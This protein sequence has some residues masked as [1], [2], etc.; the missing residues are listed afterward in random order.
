MGDHS[1][2]KEPF[3]QTKRPEFKSQVSNN[4]DRYVPESMVVM[5]VF[6]KLIV[7]IVPP[8]SHSA[9]SE[10]ILKFIQKFIGM[11]S[12]QNIFEKKKANAEDSNCL[13]S[14]LTMKQ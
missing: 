12:N 14:R 5:T 11:K 13:I 7:N 8:G 6:F 1:F 3:N 2:V 10:T 9:Q 4:K